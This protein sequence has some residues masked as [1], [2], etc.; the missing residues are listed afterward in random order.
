[1]DTG[2]PEFWRWVWLVATVV[3]GLGEIAVAGSFFLAPF[4]LGAAVAAILGFAGVAVAVQWAVFLAVSVAS[5]LALRPLARRMDREGPEL[6][7]GAHR[8]VGQSARVI[9]P[10]DGSHDTG[11]VVL[12]GERWRAESADGHAVPAGAR[13]SVV[14]VRGTRLLIRYDPTDTGPHQIDPPSNPR[15]PDPT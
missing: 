7:I 15:D 9:E 5:F 11:V 1:M 4:A 12:G 10:I 2:S 8:Q 6:G 14:K 3:F 13:V